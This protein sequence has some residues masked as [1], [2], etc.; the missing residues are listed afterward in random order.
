MEESDARKGLLYAKALIIIT[1]RPINSWN[2]VAVTGSDVLPNDYQR[3]LRGDVRRVYIV[4]NIDCE[5]AHAFNGRHRSPTRKLISPPPFSAQSICTSRGWKWRDQG[6]SALR[7]P[8]AK[9]EPVQKC[10]VT[11]GGLWRAEGREFIAQFFPSAAKRRNS[12]RVHVDR[13]L[14]PISLALSLELRIIWMADIYFLCSNRDCTIRNKRQYLR[15]IEWS[16]NN[17]TG[18]INSPEGCA[19]MYA[20]RSLQVKLIITVT[21]GAG[22]VIQREL[23]Y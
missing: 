19:C 4:R 7:W 23:D 15:S 22:P 11:S 3:S 1:R 16:Y 21:Y 5:V 6:S 17:E 8:R 10:N 9:G 20:T 13:F 18:V 2:H 12:R 14:Q